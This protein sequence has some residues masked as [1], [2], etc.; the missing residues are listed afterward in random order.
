M[1]ELALPYIGPFGASVA[2]PG[3]YLKQVAL[4][5]M[6]SLTWPMLA[7]LDGS[8]AYVVPIRSNL[9]RKSPKSAIF[10]LP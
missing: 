4:D 8:W 3:Q 2:V 7:M 10:F 9:P 6:L 1:E 5:P